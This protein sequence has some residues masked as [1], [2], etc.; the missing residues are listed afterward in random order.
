M[1]SYNK[2]YWLFSFIIFVIIG[3]LLDLNISSLNLQKL[4]ENEKIENEIAEINFTI[5]FNK[6]LGI[7]DDEQLMNNII[8]Q[9]LI[10]SYLK[11]PAYYVKTKSQ[12]EI[13]SV[14]FDDLSMFNSLEIND[15]SNFINKMLVKL[16][17]YS[18]SKNYDVSIKK[19]ENL[20]LFLK[21]EIEES[22]D[23]DFIKLIDF[24]FLN[25]Y[26]LQIN[27]IFDAALSNKTNK[28]FINIDIHNI[29]MYEAFYKFIQSLSN[30]K[31]NMFLSKIK[32]NTYLSIE[33]D[34]SN[35]YLYSHSLKKN[36]EKITLIYFDDLHLKPSPKTNIVNTFPIITLAFIFLFLLF[37]LSIRVFKYK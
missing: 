19:I 25:K 36:N 28:D 17:I 2:L 8:N 34:K 10:D 3:V 21:N 20:Y 30:E 16:K 18:T 35:I 37:F 22:F 27:R 4:L 1:I 14:K 15:L 9:Y 13:S 5:F 24:N 32:L 33:E 7:L 26:N 23:D 31:R 29:F 6:K 11:K 12:I